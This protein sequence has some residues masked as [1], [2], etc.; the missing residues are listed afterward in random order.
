MRNRKMKKWQ[1]KQEDTNANIKIEKSTASLSNKKTQDTTRSL[2]YRKKLPL[3]G[4]NA[5]PYLYVLGVSILVA[6]SLLGV[7][8]YLTK[9]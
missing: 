9:R 3:T 2:E 7:K 8:K 1:K 5:K 6:L 4:E